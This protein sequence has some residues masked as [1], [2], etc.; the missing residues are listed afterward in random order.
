MD[1]RG[2]TFFVGVTGFV[3]WPLHRRS[4]LLESF[5]KL[6]SVGCSWSHPGFQNGLLTWLAVPVGCLRSALLWRLHVTSGPHSMVVG[7]KRRRQKL[8]G[9]LPPSL[10]SPRI[11]PLLHSISQASHCGQPRFKGRE[12][13]LYLS[14]WRAAHTYG[15]GRN[16]G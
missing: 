12:L 2:G 10:R 13:R 8:Q 9:F 7:S 4:S 3:D 15:E 14:T 6:R 5:L 16:W 11:S 1:W